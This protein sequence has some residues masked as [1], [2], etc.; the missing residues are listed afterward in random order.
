MRAAPAA[1][2][3]VA[4]AISQEGKPYEWAAEGPYSY[5]CSGLVLTSYRSV[6]MGLPRVAKD[7]YGYRAA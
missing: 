2:A 1:L 7:Q 3:A 5:D 4:F 6:G